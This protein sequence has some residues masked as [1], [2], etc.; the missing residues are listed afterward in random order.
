MKGLIRLTQA[1]RTQSWD[2]AGPSSS[3][4]HRPSNAKEPQDHARSWLRSLKLSSLI[5]PTQD[6]LLTCLIHLPQSPTVQIPTLAHRPSHHPAGQVSLPLPQWGSQ[7]DLKKSFQLV[8]WQT[9]PCPKVRKLFFL[10]PDCFSS[11][12]NFLQIDLILPPELTPCL[13]R[14]HLRNVNCSLCLATQLP[15]PFQ[16]ALLHHKPPSKGATLSPT[17]SS[18]H[19][20]GAPPRSWREPGTQRIQIGWPEL[21]KCLWN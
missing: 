18:M 1:G 9:L 10:Y 15:V 2:L 21:N 8:L 12:T 4:N 20:A 7:K 13:P 16:P 17:F 6:T 19:A 3:H 14:K 5:P 11:L